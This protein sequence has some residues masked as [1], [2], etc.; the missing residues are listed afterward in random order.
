MKKLIIVLI[1]LLLVAG[2]TGGSSSE[3]IKVGDTLTVTGDVV[4]A[5]TSRDNYAEMMK[6]VTA[7]D[8]TGFQAMYNRGQ[9][10]LLD[11]G[12]RVK[13]LDTTFKGDYEVRVQDGPH[14]EEVVR[15]SREFLE[16]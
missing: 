5:A 12:T 11:K 16:K 7:G 9:I 8:R 3:V 4:P 15:V 14:R 1:V 6:F 10:I 2:C 13:L